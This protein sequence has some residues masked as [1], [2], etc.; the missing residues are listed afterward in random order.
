MAKHTNSSAISIYNLAPEEAL[1]SLE[2]SEHGL[3]QREASIRLSRYGANVLKPRKT[4]L[5][6]RLLEPF[7]SLFVSILVVAVVIS[8]FNHEVADAV[9]IS[10]VLVANALIYYL[11]QISANRVLNTLK[12]HDQSEVSVIRD[13]E[14]LSI[15]SEELVPGDVIYL[16][17]G[18]K[19][20]ADGRLIKSDGLRV[21]ESSLTGESLPIHKKTAAIVGQKEVFDQKNMVFKG[22]LIHGGNAV[23]AVTATGNDTEL[24]SIGLM[25]SAEAL[26]RSPIEHKIDSLTRKIA[27][28]V[29]GVG[30][31]VFLLALIRGMELSEALRF[32]LSLVVSL[33]PEG[34]PVALTVVL[35][36][37][38]K[39][40]AKSKALVRKIASIETLGAVT[41]I[42]VDKTG[43]LTK[44][45]LSVTESYAASNHDDLDR[46]VAASLN[47]NG[48]GNGDPLDRVLYNV[49][50]KKGLTGWQKLKDYPFTQQLRASGAAWKDTGGQITLFVKGAPEHLLRSSDNAKADADKVLADYSRKGYRVIGFAHKQITSVPVKL[51]EDTLKGLKFDGLVGLADELRPGID[52]AVE[53]ARNAGIKVVMLTGD[54]IETAREIGRRIGLINKDAEVTDSRALEVGNSQI[55]QKLEQINVFG[56]VLPKHKF[57]FLKAV[58]YQ[59]IT[60]M[61][62]DGVNDVPAL[63]E[64]DIGLAMG[65]GT[66]AA[67]DASEIVLLDNDFK[68]ILKAISLG[69][70]VVANVRKMLFYVISTGVGEAVTMLGALIWELPLPVTAAQILW[71]N[72]VTDGFTVLPLGLGKPE[73]HQMQRKP[74]DPKAPLLDRVYIS[75]IVLTGTAMAVVTLLIFN[76]LLPK[77]YVY[78]QSGAFMALVVAQWA[79][80][81]NADYERFS[82]VRNFTKPNWYLW[83]GLTLAIILQVAVFIEPLS[84]F[85]GLVSL[86]AADLALVTVLP[87]SV[88]LLL[89]DFHKLVF[90]RLNNQ[91]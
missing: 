64:A 15:S 43:T 89:G 50:R 32:S 63:V 90:R 79:N 56:R 24:G 47:F 84:K 23:V 14:T 69:R 30:A 13:G 4:P 61:T 33:V 82:W 67:K 45:Q 35:L 78:A 57:N 91:S 21:D 10:V 55:R 20:P 53:R 29:G 46:I 65:S 51:S 3:S 17:E 7:A 74:D 6:K 59:E 40:M 81:L 16:S 75:R 12:K 49:F 31:G 2:T 39:R 88:V 19:V 62:G 86:S 54:H 71:I 8:L 68:T 5:W 48:D 58:K 44:N 38:A 73:R 1:I 22:T 72:L 87:I 83:G 80:S 11:Q 36:L 77:G 34:L 28:V 26:E 42:A 76:Y 52:K 25:A 18:M 60:A 9:I 41:L 70:S 27:I 85:F 66:D 37:S